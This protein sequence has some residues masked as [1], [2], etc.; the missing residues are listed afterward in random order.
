MSAWQRSQA[1]DFMKYPEGMYWPSVVCAELGKNF[2][3]GPSPSC[4]IVAGE[5][6]SHQ[7]QRCDTCC[8]PAKTR[9]QPSSCGEPRSRQKNNA[10]GAQ[11]NMRI[12]PSLQAMRRSQA[13]Q[14]QAQSRACCQQ[15]PTGTRQQPFPADSLKKK[16]YQRQRDQHAQTGVQKN[17]AGIKERRGRIS[18]K[19]NC[20]YNQDKHAKRAPAFH[21]PPSQPDLTVLSPE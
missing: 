14:R 9:A 2:P 13:N 19:I 15:N 12:Q 21:S 6:G 18:V 10:Q 16:N 7:Q 8:L 11:G 3:W 17:R 20:S 5:I 4:N 1:C